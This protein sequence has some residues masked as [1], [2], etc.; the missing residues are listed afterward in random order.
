MNYRQKMVSLCLLLPL[1]VVAQV[2]FVVRDM[3]VEG[4]QRISE[5]TVF[6]YLPINIGDNVDQVRIQE[7][8]RALYGQGL[9]DDIEMRRDGDTLVVAVRERPS[10]ESFE[11]EGNKDIK[12]EDLTESLR[13]VGLAKGKTFDRSVL[14]EVSSF[15]REQYYDRGKYGVTVDTSVVES[16]NNTVRVRIDVNEGERAKIRQVNL[17]GN[18][19]FEEKDIRA[20]FELDTANWLSWIRQ[21]D[22]Y[23]KE[24]LEGD[25]EKLRAYYMDR[26]YADFRVESTQV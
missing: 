16:A 18:A 4:L 1:T 22:R 2:N 13:G 15:L 25:L 6:N 21:D 8:I 24:A 20:D 9:F 23:S 7:A 10:I 5:G 17:V 26:G 3:R 12:T 19:A 11:I 14:D